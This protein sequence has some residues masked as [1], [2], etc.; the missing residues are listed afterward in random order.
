[1][2]IVANIR[3]DTV[4]QKFTTKTI[5]GTFPRHEFRPNPPETPNHPQTVPDTRPAIVSKNDIYSILKYGE[6]LNSRRFCKISQDL[7]FF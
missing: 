7:Y 6:F 4:K 5:F 2:K 1:M 3:K